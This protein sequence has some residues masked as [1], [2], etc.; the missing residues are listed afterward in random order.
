MKK[1]AS[2]FKSF[3]YLIIAVALTAGCRHQSGSADAEAPDIVHQV[4]E[5]GI[6]VTLSLS[7]GRIDPLNDAL[8]TLVTRHP[9]TVQIA[10]PEPAAALEGFTIA[11]ALTMPDT[12]EPDGSIVRETSLRLSPL[13]GASYRIAPMLFGIRTDANGDTRY[14]ITP[15][16]RPATNR[17][18]EQGT[19]VL[20]ATPEPIY[21]PPTP[22]EIAR[23]SASIIALALLVVAISIAFIK[24]R[25]RIQI[26]RM[27]PTERARYELDQLLAQ[28]LP[29]QGKYKEF[30]FAITLIIRTYIERQHGIRAPEL[31]TPEFLSA[32]AQ[33]PSFQPAVVDRLKQFLESADL[34]KF[35][36]W[37]PDQ[38]AVQTAIETARN[39]LAEDAVQTSMQ[40]GH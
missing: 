19:A 37:T 25:R 4:R 2:T 34:V 28:D 3:A 36:A 13:P 21:I 12:R 23:W 40:G 35:A 31:T 10:F 20:L 29:A 16:I 22:A 33:R 8:L 30:Y 24:I 11:S 14:V 32:A 39:Y 7:P 18:E 6:S 26:Y 1:A 15:A 38:T 5:H 27:S 9:A 17:M